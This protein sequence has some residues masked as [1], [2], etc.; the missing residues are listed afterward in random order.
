MNKNNLEFLLKSIKDEKPS[1]E[2]YTLEINS[3][4]E[5][6][7]HIQFEVEIKP[8]DKTL[9][10][11]KLDESVSLKREISNEDKEIINRIVDAIK[12]GNK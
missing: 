7:N 6:N 1:D 3:L 4:D 5:N 8:E 11:I 12:T 2:S 9:G 10:F